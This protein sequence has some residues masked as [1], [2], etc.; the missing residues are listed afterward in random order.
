MYATFSCHMKK[1]EQDVSASLICGMFFSGKEQ[2]KH[3]CSFF[4][5]K[6][7]T[8]QQTCK[9]FTVCLVLCGT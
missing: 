5:N 2:I 1:D 6:K 8:Q 7:E 3:Q 9:I 4:L